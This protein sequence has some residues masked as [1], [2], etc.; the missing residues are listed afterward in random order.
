MPIRLSNIR[1]TQD[2]A[3]G[4][5]G[6]DSA[7]VTTIASGTGIQTFSTLDSLPISSLTAGDRAFVEAN[8]RLY[9][10]NGNGWFNVALVNLSPTM[11]LDPSGAITLSTDGTASTV[12]ITAS[13]SDNPNALLSFSV[14]SDGNM[15]ATGT[16]VTQDSSVFTINPLTADSGGVAGNFTLTFKTTDAINVASSSTSFSLSFVN[17]VDSSA[18]TYALVKATGNAVSNSEITYLHASDASSN[19]TEANNPRAATFSPYRSGGY[20]YFNDATNTVWLEFA[21]NSNYQMVITEDWSIEAWVHLNEIGIYH[22][23]LSQGGPTTRTS[24]FGITNT[25]TLALQIYEGSANKV[26]FYGSGTIPQG[27]WTHVAVTHETTGSTTG[28]LRFYINGVEDAST[29]V[30][31]GWSWY[32]G[33]AFTNGWN[34]GRYVYS[35]I[36]HLDGYMRDLRVLKGSR[37]YTSNFT[38][39]TEQLTAVTN[40]VL[41][42]CQGPFIA[43]RSS[44]AAAV[45]HNGLPELHPFGPYDYEAWTADNVGGSV[46]LGS[47]SSVYANDTGLVI[48]TSE[49][50][51][52]GWYYRN[53]SNSNGD[54][55]V[56][57]E[58]RSSSGN[59][60]TGIYF[61][62]EDNGGAAAGNYSTASTTGSVYA[63]GNNY[64]G[65]WSHFVLQRTSTQFEIYHNGTRVGTSTSGLT[66]NIS[67]DYIRIGTNYVNQAGHEG[68]VADVK[69]TVGSSKYSGATI[70]LPTSPVSHDGTGTKLLMQNKTDANVFDLSG[71]AAVINA[72]ASGNILTSTS[73]RQFN[74]ASSLDLTSGSGGSRSFK[75]VRENFDPRAFVSGPFT[76]EFWVYP[77]G[78]WQTAASLFTVG[79]KSGAGNYGAI[80]FYSNNPITM[81]SSS[82]GSNWNKLSNVSTGI[83]HWTGSWK[84]IAFCVYSDASYAVYLDGTRTATGSASALINLENNS[85]FT[86]ASADM[87]FVLNGTVT[88]AQHAVNG[89]F[90]DLR[91]SSVAKYSGA[92]I[93][94]PAAEFS[95]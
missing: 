51:Y 64:H 70:T 50:T 40:T 76:V 69:L 46:Y 17:I 68:Y 94:P 89:Y 74:T 18:E 55:V 43:D 77:N 22:Y 19:F 65:Q 82:N 16:T 86:N 83:S 47:T 90:Q 38:P 45:T 32:N 36:A 48:G 3:I 84:H 93:T 41:L 7:Q 80:L 92:S 88:E 95:L 61:K 33:N 30:T 6:L 15:L 37:A 10:S 35:N 21:D 9:I 29:N 54:M 2:A 63:N 14:E 27:E 8:K 53:K 49:F 4:A 56:L 13:D 91:L 62:L 25:N 1:K 34:V 28:T 81:F 52:E 66:T 39:P 78:S 42:T 44:T 20:S 87:S 59:A 11:S 60:S 72:S 31:G 5:D 23:I 73:Q 79:W 26:L 85:L 67:N 24:A 57:F 75:L 12:T 58:G 71:S